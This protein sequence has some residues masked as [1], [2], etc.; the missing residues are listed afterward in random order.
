[1]DPE[2]AAP[3]GSTPDADARPRAAE[4][5][6]ELPK[7]VRDALDRG[8]PRALTEGDRETIDALVELGVSE[9]E[10]ELAVVERRVPLVLTSQVLGE[11]R[12]HTLAEVSEASGVPEAVLLD[13]RSATGLPNRERYTDTDVEW[14]RLLGRLLELIPVEAVV[15][16]ARA[17][18]AA[19]ASIARSDLS[20]VR[21]E[22]I[23]PMREGG[24]DDLAVSVALAETAKALDPI[25][26]DILVA[27]YRLQLRDELDSELSAI[28][29]REEG[30][31]LDLA[32]GFVDVVGYTALSARID[33]EG[34]DHLLDAFQERVVEVVAEA[35]DVALVKY[36]GD[37]VMLVAGD[38][39]TLAETMLA[40]TET[41]EAL[42]EAP[43]RGG[44]AA[45]GVHVREGDFF[46]APVN[47]AARLTDMARAWSLL[48]DD[49]L[50]DPLD[51][52]FDVKRI[53]PT[54][55]RGIGLRRPLAVR[56]RGA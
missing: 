23:L 56:R 35:T 22:L 32:I 21:D 46:G 54:R 28:A 55:I 43:L 48:A 2:D 6:G 33:P 34:L 20:V 49:E 3:D 52:V 10:A 9:A 7:V 27:S 38:P 50:L 29:A 37:A 14:A 12:V 4:L 18:G 40:L 5:T 44:L 26:R 30:H 47:L 17:R 39:V 45:G 8:R 16:S 53:L 24:A 31:E 15:R 36:L 19:L 42:E 41:V 13:I 11:Q 1:M 25:S 51:D